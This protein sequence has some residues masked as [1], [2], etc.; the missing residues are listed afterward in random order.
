[1]VWVPFAEFSMQ[2]GREGERGREG[3]KRE[4]ERERGGR[5]KERAEP[6]QPQEHSPNE[7]T[8]RNIFLVRNKY[9]IFLL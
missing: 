8:S 9:A 4:R 5:E 1:M 6:K 2:K 7:V 3:R